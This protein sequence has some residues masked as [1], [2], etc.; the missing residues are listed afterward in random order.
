MEEHFDPMRLKILMMP[1]KGS[2]PFGKNPDFF[3][4]Q[5]IDYLNAR[6]V[7]NAIKCFEKG[8]RDKSTHLLCRFNLGYTLFQIGHFQAAVQHYEVLSHQC[9]E[10]KIHPPSKVPSVLYN[11]CL[12]ELQAG[13]LA[14]AAA[15]AE[16]CAE[17]MKD[18]EKSSGGNILH[19]SK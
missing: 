3:F 16:K 13:M 14:Q 19:L 6:E 8:V 2:N 4:V 1:K 11:K 17:L 7:E 12:C 10:L 5:G 15:T 18:R 9:L